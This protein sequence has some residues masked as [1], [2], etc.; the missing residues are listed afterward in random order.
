MENSYEDILV[1]PSVHDDSLSSI[2][3]A[4]TSPVEFLQE[5]IDISGEPITK[6]EEKDVPSTKSVKIKSKRKKLEK[7]FLKFLA[8]EK[9]AKLKDMMLIELKKN[10]KAI[11]DLLAD[12]EI[13]NKIYWRQ[14]EEAKNTTEKYKEEL[15]E[16]CMLDVPVGCTCCY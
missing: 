3:E 6:T 15:Q 7:S 5:I 1:I 10:K 2:G 16:L 13:E 11:E 4:S 14:V 12:T 9:K 8:V